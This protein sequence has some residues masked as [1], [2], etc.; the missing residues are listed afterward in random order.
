MLISLCQWWIKGIKNVQL[1]D[2]KTENIPPAFTVEVII[3]GAK[4]TLIFYA[5]MTATC[6]SWQW[7]QNLSPFIPNY[8]QLLLIKG[9]NIPFL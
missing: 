9:I 6:K 2:G 3:P 5:H 7:N 4:Q 8:I 1:L